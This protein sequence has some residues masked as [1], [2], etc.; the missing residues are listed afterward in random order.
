MKKIIF[1][2]T[3]FILFFTNANAVTLPVDIEA[4]SAILIN[5]DEDEVIYEKNADKVQILAS[6]TKIMTVYTALQHIDD[7]K[8]TTIITEKD[9]QG[10]EGMTVSKPNLQ[11]G[12]KVTYEDLLYWTMLWSAADTA[13]A[14]GNRV[15]GTTDAFVDM[16]N[17]EA[18]KLKLRNTNFEDT[19][20]GH[21]DNISTAREMG[22]LLS[23]AL[24]DKRFENIFKT[25]IYH[26]TNGSPVVNSTKNYAI[27]HGLD[28]NL[29]TGNK[30]GYTPE[31][32]LLLAST[33]TINDTEYALIVMNCEPNPYMTTH[34]LDSYRVYDYVKT[35]H[36]ERRTILEKDTLLKK[37]RV[38]NGTINEYPVYL[39]KT[40]TKILSDEDYK[41]VKV[42]YNIVDKIDYTSKVGDNIGFVDVLIDDEIIASESIYLKDK[43]YE[44]NDNTQEGAS[45][46]IPTIALAV[47]FFFVV[48]ISTKLFFKQS[49][50][51]KKK[52]S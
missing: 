37:I 12:E 3:C 32:G 42:E 39:P 30:T 40:I 29:I 52:K 23:K 45:L 49:K 11:V 22:T 46:I 28:E 7:I 48:A 13:Q 31:A 41:K 25:T 6:L 9:W 38:V 33:A 8:D 51:K 10:I 44:T 2:L 15:G 27:F 35:Q 4:D 17:K 24:K 21:D 1:L 34:V 19:F 18:K 16:M 14:L 47:S 26:S 43:L 50:K 20:G 36:F 5:L